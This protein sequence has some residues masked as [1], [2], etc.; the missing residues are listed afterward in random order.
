MASRSHGWAW[1]GAA[2]LAAVVATASA[3]HA[4]SFYAEAAK[5]YKGT[6]IRVLDEITPL[7]ETLTKIVPDFTKETGIN[8]EWELLNH[9]EVIN[10][11]QADML[12]GRGYYDAVML[13]GFQYGPM[14]AAGVVL[15]LDDLIKNA[16]LSNPALD[17]ADFIPKPYK[18]LAFYGGKQYSFIN[19]A[20]N[21]V[22]WARADLLGD[23]GEQAAF[24][25]KYGYDLAPAKTFDQMRDI[26]E[27]FTRK[28]GAMLAGKPLEADFYGIVLEGIKGG[29]TFL[30][31]WGNYIKNYGGDIVDASGK[32]TFN[33]PENL[34]GIKMWA[35]LW[36]FAPPGTAEASLIDVPTIMGN[37]IA[38]QTIAWS[39]F[40]LGIDQPGKSPYAGKFVYGSIPTVPGHEAA[41]AADA[42]PSGTVINASSKHPEATFLFMQWLVDKSTQ[43]KLIKAGHG[44]VPIR[45]SSWAMPELSGGPLKG[46]FVAMKS[47]LDVATAKPKM[48]KFFEI[49]DE[50]SGLSQEIGLGKVSPEDGAKRGQEIMVK[51]CGQKC[52]L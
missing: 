52:M 50:L 16:K 19:W 48:P 1:A 34:A 8:V 23:P 4:Q 10:K 20:Y 28:K 11:G 30:S 29:S 3:A 43:E 13:H 31:M 45:T 21:Q 22:Y 15:P 47:T 5:P 26:A 36:K 32:P 44:G 2:T 24:K 27:F 25:A 6:T 46:L 37:G 39:D 9:F 42:E 17:S 51:Y 7:Q 49:Y 41:R 33:T 40:V 35:S 12:S 18:S 14:L 38:A